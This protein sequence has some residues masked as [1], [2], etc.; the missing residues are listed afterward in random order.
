MS[1]DPNGVEWL[2]RNF[3]WWSILLSIRIWRC[4][5]LFSGGFWIN[6]IFCNIFPILILS[7]DWTESP[8]GFFWNPSTPE[9]KLIEFALSKKSPKY[10]FPTSWRQQNILSHKICRGENTVW[11]KNLEC[12]LYEYVQRWP[13]DLLLEFLHKKGTIVLISKYSTVLI[14][15]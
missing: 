1:I 12:G 15:L 8:S 10:F 5:C 2:E 7:F 9:Q 6:A 13:Q 4:L 3:M 11:C 14:G